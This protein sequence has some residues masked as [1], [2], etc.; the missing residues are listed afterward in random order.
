MLD[1][2]FAFFFKYSPYVFEQGELRLAFSSPV[3]IAIAIAAAALTTVLTYR[4]APGDATWL[5]RA[6]LITLRLC[7][8]GLSSSASSGRYL[9]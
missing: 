5:D 3:Y 7:L 6:V 1:S 2:L 4:S 9:F 8:V